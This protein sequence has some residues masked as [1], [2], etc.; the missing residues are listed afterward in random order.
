MGCTTTISP[1]FIY[2]QTEEHVYDR[3]R[4]SQLGSGRI[5]KIGEDC[6]YGS[7]LGISGLVSDSASVEIASYNAGITKIGSIDYKSI[8]ILGHI[9]FRHCVVVFGE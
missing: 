3:S 9:F 7:I 2:N 8:S 5:L 1:G 4:G 6:V